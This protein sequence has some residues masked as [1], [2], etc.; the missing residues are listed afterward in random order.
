MG[1]EVFAGPC[2]I[3]TMAGWARAFQFV[4][5]LWWRVFQTSGLTS[6]VCLQRNVFALDWPF[7]PK[8]ALSKNRCP[9]RTYGC[10][11]EQEIYPEPC[12]VFPWPL[13][14]RDTFRHIRRTQVERAALQEIEQGAQPTNRR[15]PVWIWVKLNHQ[16]TTINPLVH[17]PGFHFGFFHHFLTAA[18]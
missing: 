3:T 5:S 7:N 17:L 14:K 15:F 2:P 6:G 16:G 1:H 11:S 12:P 13:P 8:R 4:G 9:L 18:I 10:V